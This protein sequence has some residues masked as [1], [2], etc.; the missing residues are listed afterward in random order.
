VEALA[1]EQ[2]KNQHL[3]SLRQSQV[4]NQTVERDQIRKLRYHHQH[5]RT[6][7]QRIEMRKKTLHSTVPLKYS[8]INENEKNENQSWITLNYVKDYYAN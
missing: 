3:N 2:M 6:I 8:S 1:T 4:T 5:L 7:C